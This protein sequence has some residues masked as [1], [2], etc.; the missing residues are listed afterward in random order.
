VR[1]RVRCIGLIGGDTKAICHI[2]TQVV[3]HHLVCP[4]ADVGVAVA[5]DMLE[6]VGCFAFVMGDSAFR[7]Y[8][9]A[10]PAVAL[11]RAQA[12]VDVLLAVDVDWFEVFQ[13]GKVAGAQ[14]HAGAGGDL[15]GAAAV[16]PMGFGL[17]A[18]ING[19]AQ[20]AFFR[21]D[22]ADALNAAI[23]AEQFGLRV[24]VRGERHCYQENY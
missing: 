14:R 11:V 21:E 8:P 7:G 4:V 2:V 13:V 22:D 20:R 15:V 23:R 6:P 17:Q 1:Q 10:R 3:R 9:T 16:G 12:Q 19:V 5:F 24:R 18:G